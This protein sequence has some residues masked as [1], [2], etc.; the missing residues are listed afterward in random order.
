[1]TCG[2]ERDGNPAE[3]YWL[4]VRHT[5]DSGIGLQP[6]T[7][8]LLAGARGEIRPGTPAGMVTMRMG[9]HRPIHRLPRVDVEV[10][11]LA[12]ESAIGKGEEGHD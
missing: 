5:P 1:M 2:V 10:A 12:I 8:H 9:D 11:G 3:A 7:E 6:R 4:A